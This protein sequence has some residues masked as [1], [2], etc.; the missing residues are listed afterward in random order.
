MNMKLLVSLLLALTSSLANAQL[1]DEMLGILAL[2]EP[3]KSD[4]L[5][6]RREAFTSLVSSDDMSD[7]CLDA[8]KSNPAHFLETI[9]YIKS[10]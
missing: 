1:S 9:D 8:K 7:I 5:N 6:E 10:E 4:A 2:E 3:S